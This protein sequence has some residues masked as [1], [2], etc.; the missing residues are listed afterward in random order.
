MSDSQISQCD[1]ALH[2]FI[3]NTNQIYHNYTTC[4]NICVSALNVTKLHSEFVPLLAAEIVTN[5]TTQ[6]QGLIK[7]KDD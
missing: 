1:N 6:R 3:Y 7:V 4:H 5:K 2:F